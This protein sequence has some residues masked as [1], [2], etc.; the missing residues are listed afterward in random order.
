MRE[1]EFES[2]DTA[3]PFPHTK[4]LPYLPTVPS[5]L[6]VMHGME[7]ETYDFKRKKI[8]FSTSNLEEILE[9]RNDPLCK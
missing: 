9:Y 5:F 2:R 7:S 8:N 1:E 4:N 6:H 3:E